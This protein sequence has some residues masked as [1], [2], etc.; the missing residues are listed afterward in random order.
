MNNLKSYFVDVDLRL[1]VN[2]GLPETNN[3]KQKKV[4]ISKKN[5]KKQKLCRWLLLEVAITHAMNYT[6]TR[7]LPMT[8]LKS[9]VVVKIPVYLYIRF[10]S[11]REHEY[12]Y[13]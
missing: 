12:S 11:T 6:G 9:L 3:E 13:I 2:V 7:I 4:E 10:L 5:S 1:T 8:R